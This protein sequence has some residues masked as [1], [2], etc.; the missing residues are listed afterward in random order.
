MDLS[1]FLIALLTNLA[2]FTFGNAVMLAIGAAM[3][4][5]GVARRR[6]TSLLLVPAGFGCILVNSGFADASGLF[7]LVNDVGVQTGLLPLLMLVGAGALVD[8]GPL[9]AYPRLAIYGAAVQL[10]IF[11]ILVLAVVW[12]F[13]PS[14]AASIGTIGALSGPAAIFVTSRLAPGLLAPVTVAAFAFMSLLP[15]VRSAIVRL[16][17]TPDERG[18]HLGNT[19]PPVSRVVRLAF[20]VLVALF[21]SLIAPQAAPLVAALLLG[22]LLRESQV[23]NLLSPPTRYALIALAAILLGLAIGMLMEAASFLSL[24]TLKIF[25]LGL[26]GLALNLTLGFLVGKLLSRLSKSRVNPFISASIGISATLAAG[27]TPPA[28]GNTKPTAGIP[29]D[30]IGANAASLLLGVIAAGLL[31]ELTSIAH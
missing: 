14:D 10:G 4:A 15:A 12:G 9:L 13:H 19:P 30:A 28:G 17:T 6:E 29:I 1:P 22:N 5:L 2:S 25:L 11:G 8:F 23:V 16:S 21:V 18:R 26:L 7:K 3:L 24:A 20:P 27:D 31:L